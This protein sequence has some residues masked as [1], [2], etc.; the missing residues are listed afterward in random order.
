[1]CFVFPQ[2]MMQVTY[3]LG[4]NDASIHFAS[5]SYDRSGETYYAAF[6]TELS[7]AQDYDDKTEWFG[8]KLLADDG[9]AAY[10]QLRDEQVQQDSPEVTL[11]YRGYIESQICLAKYDQGKKTEALERAFLYLGEGTFPVSNPVASVYV[12]ALSKG[13]A[14]TANAFLARM[15]TLSVSGAD[16]TYLDDLISLSN[17]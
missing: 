5:V 4:M 14:Q 2:T 6:A 9:F 1:M 10:A 13:D 3:D 7:I 8:E 16:R 15:Q 12:R 17:P 11:T